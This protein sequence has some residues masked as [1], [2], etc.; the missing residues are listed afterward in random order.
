MPAGWSARADG[1]VYKNADQPD[2]LGL[3]TFVVTHV[4]ADACKSE[5]TLTA[6]GSTVDDM[7]SA[8]VDQVDSDASAPV[9]VTL[10][11]HPAKR[12]DVSIPADLDLSTC[13]HPGEG[14]GILGRPGGDRLL[15]APSPNPPASWGR[16]TSPTSKMSES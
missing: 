8:L 6:V 5:G 1:Y 16:Y 11:G 15:R 13:R 4:Y 12:I 3:T 9:D 7:V 14:V 2:E 10:G